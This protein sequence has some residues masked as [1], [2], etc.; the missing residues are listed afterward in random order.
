MLMC[1]VHDVRLR[2]HLCLL[3]R[4]P[5]TVIAVISSRRLFAASTSSAPEWNRFSRAASP[6]TEPNYPRLSL[7]NWGNYGGNGRRAKRRG[8]LSLCVCVCCFSNDSTA[9]PPGRGGGGLSCS[10]HRFTCLEKSPAHTFTRS[11]HGLIQSGREGRE[12]W[13]YSYLLGYVVYRFIFYQMEESLSVTAGGVPVFEFEIQPSLFLYTGR[14]PERSDS[15]LM[16]PFTL[17]YT[18]TNGLDFLLF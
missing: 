3:S 16:C 13:G 18:G 11:L 6:L 12:G 17:L 9:E 7:Q 10:S 5:G 2:K 14:R 15:G 4:R 1:S 8:L